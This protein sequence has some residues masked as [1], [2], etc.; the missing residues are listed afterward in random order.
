MVKRIPL[1]QGKYAIVDDDVYLWASQWRW[2]A[3]KGHSVYYAVRREAGTRKWI[4]LHREIMNAPDGVD[5][6]HKDGDGLN[7]LRKNLRFCTNAQNQRNRGVQSNNTSGY[8]GVYW[9]KRSG[10]WKVQIEVAGKKIYLGLYTDLIEA[11][12]AYDTAARKYHGRFA[13]TNF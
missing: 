4:R 1:T 10:K 6:D 11:A 5:V 2:H 12:K 7:N 9:F 3:D 13:K 8:K